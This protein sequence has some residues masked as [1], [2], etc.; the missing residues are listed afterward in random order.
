MQ[1]LHDRC[2]AAQVEGEEVAVSSGEFALGKANQVSRQQ[3]TRRRR[4]EWER[5]VGARLFSNLSAAAA[6]LRG[7]RRKSAIDAIIASAKSTAD[8]TAP[9]PT[10]NT[11]PRSSGPVKAGP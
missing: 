3:Q 2:L 5:G 9:T 4:E 11:R 6:Q 7:L 8:P 10:C 1:R